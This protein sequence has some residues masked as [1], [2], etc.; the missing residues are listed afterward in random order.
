LLKYSNQIQLSRRSLSAVTYLLIH[1]KLTQTGTS[2]DP[3]G[4]IK[5]S[6]A[7]K[8]NASLTS[9]DLGCTPQVI[10]IHSHSIG[11]YIG[12]QGAIKLFEAL[13]INASLRDLDLISIR[14]VLIHSHSTQKIQLLVLMQ[15]LYC[16]K[17]LYQTQHSLHSISA[18]FYYFYFILTLYR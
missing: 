8:S 9:L 4:A 7:L 13:K 16:L 5:L 14:L 12:N 11:N 1:F 17:P 15:L 2:I 18:V 10:Q 3:E 6:E